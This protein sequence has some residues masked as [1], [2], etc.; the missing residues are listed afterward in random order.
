[1]FA[2]ALARITGLPPMIM[3]AAQV[4]NAYAVN[5]DHIHAVVQHPDGTV[6]DLWGRQSQEAVARRYAMLRWTLSEETHQTAMEEA[7]RVRP[8]VPNEVAEAD[9][10]IRQYRVDPSGPS[11]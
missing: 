5:G 8:E 4:S 2:D 9:A 11:A 3:Q 10:V 6:E 1:M 7:H